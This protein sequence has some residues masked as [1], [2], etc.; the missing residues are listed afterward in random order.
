MNEGS[1]AEPKIPTRE[2]PTLLATV[3]G[4]GVSDED[5]ALVIGVEAGKTVERLRRRIPGSMYPFV[6]GPRAAELLRALLADVERET[7]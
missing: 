5:R 7:A 2:F 4:Y 3:K 6:R 1:M